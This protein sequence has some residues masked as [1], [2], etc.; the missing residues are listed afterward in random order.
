LTQRVFGVSLVRVHLQF[1]AGGG[2]LDFFGTI[3]PYEQGRSIAV[4]GVH[5]IAS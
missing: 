4:G 5:A 2:P 1:V 3:L